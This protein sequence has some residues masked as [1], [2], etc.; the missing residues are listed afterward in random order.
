M[1]P[2]PPK[3]FGVKL[4]PQIQ[5]ALEHRDYEL[6]GELGRGGM[7]TVYLARHRKLGRRVA[8]KMLATDRQTKENSIRRFRREARTFAQIRHPHI[9]QLYEFEDT[10]STQYLALEYV[11]GTDIE[12]E[13]RR[14]RYWSAGEVGR[15]LHSLASALEHTHHKGILHRDIKPGNILIERD[16]GRM[17]LTDFGLAKGEADES[18]TATGF[19]VGTPAYMS[20]EQISDR[21]GIEPD[22]RSDLFS[23]A[24][25]AYEM[26]TGEHPFLAGD[27]ISTMRRIV[28]EKH[29]PLASLRD[30]LPEELVSVLEDMLHKDPKKRVENAAAVVQRLGPL[31]GSASPHPS[32]ADPASSAGERRSSSGSAREQLDRLLSPGKLYLLIAAVAAVT[33]I[34]GIGLG[35]LI[36][37]LA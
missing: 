20:P 6:L 17:V 7:G 21:F 33:L 36:V 12:Q 23:L 3:P 25:V 26:L 11:E 31:Y 24:V 35:I 27:D 13:R 37:S 8:I 1:S 15:M 4:D 9:A 5:Q 34:L 19:A 2:D 10:G 16:T 28:K 29:K 32:P 14:G 22:G 30:D 18:L